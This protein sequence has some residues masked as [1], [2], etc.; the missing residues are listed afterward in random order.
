MAGETTVKADLK[1][2]GSRIY[3]DHLEQL[4]TYLAQK[5]IRYKILSKETQL[6]SS[7]LHIQYLAHGPDHF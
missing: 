7:L 3:S 1:K 6:W 2:P 5:L 4:D